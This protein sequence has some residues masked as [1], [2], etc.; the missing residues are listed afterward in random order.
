MLNKTFKTFFLNIFGCNFEGLIYPPA[1]EKNFDRNSAK[2]HL[3]FPVWAADL[4]KKQSISVKVNPDNHQKKYKC[5]RSKSATTFFLNSICDFLVQFFSV[6][7][8][9]A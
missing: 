7:P 1:P 4:S 3:E 5:V 9:D 6:Q 8:V 2:W